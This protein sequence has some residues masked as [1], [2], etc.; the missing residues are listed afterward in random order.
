M[1]PQ[2]TIGNKTLTSPTAAAPMEGV[3]SIAFLKTCSHYGAGLVETQAIEDSKHNFYDMDELRRIKA[4]V[5]F[6]IMTAKPETAAELARDVSTYVDVIDLN[7]GCPLKPILGKKAGGYLLSYPHLMERVIRAVKAEVDIPVTIKIRKGFDD[8]RITFKEVA[9]MAK[10]QGVD[11][12]TLHGRTVRQAYT[13]KADWTSIME[14]STATSMPV[15]ANGDVFKP[16]QAKYLLERGYATGVMLGRAAR[17]N[18]GIFTDINNALMS[19]TG[20]SPSRKDVITTFISHFQKQRKRPLKQ[21]QD[22]VCWMLTGIKGAN[23]FKRGVR[24]A[25]SENEVKRIINEL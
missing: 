16:G 3:S 24:A 12:I 19:R 8:S 22:H 10:R 11:A 23:E 21:L 5:A 1:I 2:L 15:I 25:R 7:F 17:T 9:Q 13:G 4:I 14:L 6:Q 20:Q 18:P